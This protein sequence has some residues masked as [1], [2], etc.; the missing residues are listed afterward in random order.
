L[1]ARTTTGFY[2]DHA[3]R[4]W[5]YPVVAKLIAEHLPPGSRLVDVGAGVTPLAP[6][7]THLGYVV[8]TVDPSPNQRHWPPGPEWNEW[9]YLDYTA[10]GLANG[11]W[12]CTVGQLP[13]LPTF[14]GAYSIS[15]IEHL[16]A[17]DRRTLLADIAARVRPGG[18]TLL[19]I[20]LVRGRDD[21]W[22][23]NLGLEVE[24]LAVHGRLE[25]V[26]TEA[27]RVGLELVHQDTVRRWG[28][29]EVDI[30]LLV[31]RRSRTQSEAARSMARRI[32]SKLLRSGQ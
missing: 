29:V 4:L 12:N 19:T 24:S 18:V 14:D 6:F 31:L 9:G 28:D 7:L 3:P 11:S 25:D 20:D 22:N 2:P 32:V 27:A 10:A 23:R 16:P 13:D 8:D 30:G 17:V 15:V 21:L 1:H 26:I 5:E